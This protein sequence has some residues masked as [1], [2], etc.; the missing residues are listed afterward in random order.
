VHYARREGPI[1]VTLDNLADD[2][3]DDVAGGAAE[4]ADNV[5]DDVEKRP[6]RSRGQPSDGQ[7]AESGSLVLAVAAVPTLVVSPVPGRA[8]GG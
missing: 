5:R 7:R 3:R 8:P 1:A 2:G 4:E 6:D